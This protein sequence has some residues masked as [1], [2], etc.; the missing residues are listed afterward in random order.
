M[1]PEQYRVSDWPT[2]WGK[3]VPWET[4][5]TLSGMWGYGRDR[6]IWKDA[7]DLISLLVHAVS[8]GGNLIMNVGPTGRGEFEGRV[9]ASLDVYAQW[10]KMNSES[11]YGCTEAPARFKAP[12]ETMLTFNPRLNRL[13]IHLIAYHGGNLLL[14]FGDEVEYAQFL[15]DA[16]E[17]VFDKPD[18]WTMQR[19]YRH[20]GENKLSINLP[21]V[22]PP[23]VN[24]VVEVF[25]KE[26]K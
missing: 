3:R 8:K 11:I 15:H 21:Y 9:M 6:S 5:Q 25:L 1:T 24:P 22:K 16:S 14:D 26:A 18:P 19:Q 20:G 13:Y 17:L 7:S 23:V 12:P 4:C 10:M 2:M